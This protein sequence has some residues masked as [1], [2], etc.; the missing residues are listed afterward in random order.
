MWSFGLTYSAALNEIAETV[1]ETDTVSFINAV[2]IKNVFD[3]NG[4]LFCREALFIATRR[5]ATGECPYGSH[6]SVILSVSEESPTERSDP[7]T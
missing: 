6:K 4:F 1:S 3:V 7:R 2:D 5:R